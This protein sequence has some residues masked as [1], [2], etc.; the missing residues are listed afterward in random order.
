V[1]V[2]HI[3]DGKIEQVKIVEMTKGPKKKQALLFYGKVMA[4][5]LDPNAFSEK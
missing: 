5:E 2:P 1:K 4:L 3:W